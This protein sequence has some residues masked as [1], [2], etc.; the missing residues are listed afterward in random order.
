LTFFVRF[1]GTRGSIPTPGHSTRRYGGNTSCVELRIDDALF[2]CDGGTG[3]REL[4]DALLRRSDGPIDA[5]VLFSHTH[6]DH[7]Q[8]FPFFVPAY[9]PT[10]TLRVYD[11]ER[12]DDRVHRLLMGQMRSEY[13]PVSFVDL[14]SK[15]V[16]SNLQGGR[17]TIE[18]VVVEALEQVHPGRSYA[19][20]FGHGATKVIY[21]TDSELDRVVENHDDITARPDALR[22]LPRSIVEFVAGADLLIADAQYDDDNFRDG[23]G[24]ARASTV[25]DLAVQ[26]GVKQLALF[27][28][29]PTLSDAAVDAKVGRAAA[30]AAAAGSRLGVFGAREGIELKLG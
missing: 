12:D 4:G 21:A 5:H 28:H 27:H 9:R 3:M 14:G 17:T 1:W 8:G 7:I 25:V 26:A 18:G 29:D 20:S 19:Y 24:H 13:F 2:I 6:W 30:R 10:T 23:W 16:P 11:V 22:R 15:I